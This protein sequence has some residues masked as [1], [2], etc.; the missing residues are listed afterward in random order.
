M[1]E[2]G[3]FQTVVGLSGIYISSD[4]GQTWARP[5]NITGTSSGSGSYFQVAMTSSGQIQLASEY[6]KLKLLMSS[7]FGVTWGLGKDFNNSLYFNTTGEIIKAVAISSSGQV[8]V[9]TTSSGVI[10]SNNSG[11][12]WFV[13]KQ[14]PYY[15]VNYQCV[16]LSADGSIILAAPQSGQSLYVSTNGG[17]T[18]SMKTLTSRYGFSDV[19]MSRTGQYQ[20]AVGAN[21]G[22][23]IARSTDFGATWQNTT[24]PGYGYESVSVSSTGQ[25]M[26]AVSYGGNTGT[27]SP[28][29]QSNDF[30][31]TWFAIPGSENIIWQLVMLNRYPW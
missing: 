15:R 3:Q 13:V 4:Y 27:G 8:Q 16:T 10:I 28:L 6:G 23:P 25:V 22:R 11:V 12:D 5:R 24:S 20:L 29:V 31:T 21:V 30:G 7:D 14:I 17:A 1:S 19:G 9:V 26:L 18:W 2:T